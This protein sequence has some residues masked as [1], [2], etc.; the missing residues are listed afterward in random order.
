MRALLSVLF[1]LGMA[2]SATAANA[3]RFVTLGTEGGPLPQAD[4]SQPAN[5]IVRDDGSIMLVDAG[6][7]AAEQ[8]AKANLSITRV[9][10]IFLSHL[11]FDH[12]AGVLGVL[13]LRFQL[14]L[15][16]VVTVYGPP[17]TADFVAGLVSSMKPFAMSGFGV[18]GERLGEPQA[19]IK[20]VEI[21]DGSSVTLRDMKVTAA[22]NTHYSFPP[23]SELDRRYKSLSF[24]F[25]MKDRSVVF[26]G[27]TGPSEKVERLAKGA[28]MLVSE[29]IDVDRIVAIMRSTRPDFAEKD[30]NDLIVH[31]STQHL[32]YAAVGHLA[33]A[34]GVKSLVLTHIVP[35]TVTPAE[36]IRYREIIAKDY[37]GP[38]VFARDLDSF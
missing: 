8:L 2:A 33:K 1:A 17:G 25:D 26:T 24:R 13:A 27:D 5:A 21:G 18:P 19:G 29:V 32:S 10:T 11:H 14:G 20:V 30:I 9:D 38:V 4:R 15:P 16:G 12:T 36:E 3:E 6:D 34:A 31:Q 23:G 37:T 28:D 35:G 22:Q 7:G